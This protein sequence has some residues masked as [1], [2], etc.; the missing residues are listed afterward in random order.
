MP[1]SM[2]ATY[3][4]PMLTAGGQVGQVCLRLP[5]LIGRREADKQL[6]RRMRR[7]CVGGRRLRGG[8]GHERRR[9]VMGGVYLQA[10]MLLRLACTHPANHPWLLTALVQVVQ[11]ALQQPESGV[12]LGGG[13]ARRPRRQRLVQLRQRGAGVLA[14]PRHGCGVR[15]RGVQARG[16]SG[17]RHSA[18]AVVA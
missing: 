17:G 4:R 1:S 7:H 2:S 3:A 12:M 13:G 9:H 16:A 15:R 5:Q 8:Y 18:E 14:D 11:R 10:G 6:R